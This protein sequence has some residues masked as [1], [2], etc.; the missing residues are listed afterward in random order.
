MAIAR[1]LSIRLPSLALLEEWGPPLPTE[2]EP[3]AVVGPRL[4]IDLAESGYGPEERRRLGAHYTSG[5]VADPLAAWTLSPWRGARMAPVVVDPCAGAGALLLAAGSVLA[6]DGHDRTTLVDEH[7]AGIEIDPVAAAVAEAVLCIWCG[8]HA[9]PR[10]SVADAL[11]L[12]V[13][14]WPRQP[15]VVVANPPFLG[16]LRIQTART[17]LGLGP[18]ADLD[19]GYVDTAA[20][21]A[22][23]SARVVPA[24]GRVGLVLPESVLAATDAGPARAA[25]GQRCVP[26]VAWS[27][28]RGAFDADVATCVLVF[29]VVGSDPA[30]RA[31]GSPMTYAVGIPPVEIDGGEARISD[32]SGPWGSLLVGDGPIV[33]LG[34]LATSG[35]LGDRAEVVAD[36]RGAYYGLVGAVVDRAVADDRDY[37]PLLTSGLVDPAVSRW[38]SRSARLHRQR[39]DHPRVD[40]AAL[41]VDAQMQRW[42]GSRLV[43]K[44]VVATQTPVPEALADPDG[45]WLA[46]TPVISVV[47]HEAADVWRLGAVVSA[48][49]IAAWAARALAGSALSSGSIRLSA[50]AVRSLPLPADDSAWDRAAATFEAAHRAPDDEA[51]R[52]LLGQAGQTMG[53]AYGFTDAEADALATWWLGRL[54]A[55]PPGR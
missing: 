53:Q 40:R 31:Q 5:A 6:A 32:G 22:A 33:D 54:P 30:H 13:E 16:Q 7:L 1:R 44:V 43:P 14:H 55:G 8:G 25:V 27:P 21:F 17:R 42:V 18:V 34:D 29:D 28:G 37:P 36:F 24:G 19:R 41:Q 38:G 51:R 10:I 4:L 39:W 11:T 12:D 45:R 9:V 47:P 26:A 35:V 15:D 48:P 2:L 50:G 52:Q 23:L 46:V 49:P 20:L 3:D